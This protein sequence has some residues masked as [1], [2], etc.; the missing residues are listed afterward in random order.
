MTAND[1][2]VG[3]GSG[4]LSA[5]LELQ[6]EGGVGTNTREQGWVKACH[7]QGQGQQVARSLAGLEGHATQR[8][9][10]VQEKAGGTCGWRT[11]RTVPGLVP[12]LQHA[13]Q[14]GPYPGYMLT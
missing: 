8:E 6:P 9:Q 11:I 5:D 14:P 10:M 1:V 3:R 2:R 13:V 12:G 7:A 4:K